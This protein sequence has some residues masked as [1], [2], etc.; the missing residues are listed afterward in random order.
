MGYQHAYEWASLHAQNITVERKLVIIR[1]IMYR[2]ESEGSNLDPR[3]SVFELSFQLHNLPNC[4]TLSKL[5]IVSEPYVLV[6][7]I[8]AIAVSPLQHCCDY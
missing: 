5:F 4:L 8:Q 2:I 6:C 7:K 3:A 1:I